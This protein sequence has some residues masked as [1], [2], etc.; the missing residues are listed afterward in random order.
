MNSNKAVTFHKFESKQSLFSNVATRCEEILSESLKRQQQV[1]FIVPGG[2]TPA[3]AFE[4]LSHATLDW[5]RIVIA[6]SDERWVD[7]DHPQSNQR[8]TEENLLINN[9]S[10]ATYVAMKNNYETAVLGMQQCNDDYAALAPGFNL[11]LL[12]MGID[13]HFASL[14]PG[15][16][17]IQLNMDPNS[18]S[19]CA[20]IDATGCAVAGGYP[21]RMSLTL[22]AILN[23]EVIILLMIGM[24]KMKVIEQAIQNDAPLITPISSLVNQDKTP[25]E[26]YWCE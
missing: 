11:T 9:A 26:I 4:Q 22:S 2:S 19:M 6:Q 16:K 8:L 17:N 24:E 25:V 23:S 5:Q 12:G 7:R 1:S 14:F 20:S 3:P 15:S 13:G 18:P 10:N 21:E